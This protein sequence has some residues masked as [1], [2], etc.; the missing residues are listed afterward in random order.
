[1]IALLRTYLRPYARPLAL[2][3]ALLVVQAIA[4][5][6]LPSLRSILVFQATVRPHA[7]CRRC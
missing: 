2:V 3:V 4:T 1:M 7:A 6:Y 5:L